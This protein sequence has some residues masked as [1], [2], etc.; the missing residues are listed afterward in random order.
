MVVINAKD[1]IDH[2]ALWKATFVDLP[3][4][5][6]A[7]SAQLDQLIQS[8]MADRQTDQWDALFA[9]K[10]VRPVLFLG[11]S[12][13]CLPTSE[14]DKTPTALKMLKVC[15]AAGSVDPVG[16][17]LASALNGFMQT[18]TLGI[19]GSNGALPR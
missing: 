14:G 8:A 3:S 5:I 6:N 15:D 2:D 16:C 7:L 11:Q 13:V 17:G 9:R 1:A 4:A 18:I 12:L 10:V 19:P